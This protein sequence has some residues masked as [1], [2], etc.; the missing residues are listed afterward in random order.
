MRK[1]PPTYSDLSASAR[2]ETSSDVSSGL[3]ASARAERLRRIFR[4]KRLSACGNV[5]R[6]VFR[7]VRNVPDVFRLVQKTYLPTWALSLSA[8]GTSS[9]IPT[10]AERPTYRLVRLSACGNILRRTDFGRRS[11]CGN[12][13]RR[14]DFGDSAPAEASCFRLKRLS[15]CGTSFD[16][17]TL[18]DSVSAC[19]NVRRRVFRLK[20]LSACGTSFDVP[21]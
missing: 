19:G 16:G 15:A 2:A 6:R 13:L 5:R 18:G 21:T 3:S 7:L 9:D 11:A 4:L 12:V 14:T 20:R 10:C 17:P 8:C 1:R